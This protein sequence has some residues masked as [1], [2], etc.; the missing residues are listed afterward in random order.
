MNRPRL[1]TTD[2]WGARPPSEPIDVLSHRP[3][4]ILIHHTAGPNSSDFSQAHAFELARSIQNFHM[5]VRHWRDTGQHF[6]ISRGGYAMAGRHRSIPVL[7]NG[8]NHVLGAHCDGQNDVA[9]GIEN[10]GTYTSATPPDALYN[11]LVSL[12]AY[13]CQQYGLGPGR[14]FGHRDFNATECPGDRL[15]AMLPRL[16]DDV[17]QRLASA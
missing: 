11:K 15:Y 5:D 17:R 2:E 9:I 13:I 4:K 3:N 8:V 12:C 1:Y 14:I 16:R 10:E 6:T 7:D